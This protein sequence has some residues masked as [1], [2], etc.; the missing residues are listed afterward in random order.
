[1]ASPNI[2]GFNETQVSSFATSV[3]S[4]SATLSNPVVA[5]SLI[6]VSPVINSASGRMFNSGAVTDSQGNTYT[7]QAGIDETDAVGFWT[8]IAGSSGSLTVT[9]TGSASG[10]MSIFVAEHTVPGALTF[11]S[12]RAIQTT[13]LS[14][15]TAD[16]TFV[17]GTNGA[18]YYAVCAP[19]PTPAGSNPMGGAGIV[20]GDADWFTYDNGGNSG[21]GTIFCIAAL[22]ILDGTRHATFTMGARPGGTSTITL[23]FTMVCANSGT[24]P[25][26]DLCVN[27]ANIT[28]LPY[29]DTQDI[30]GATNSS[31]DPVNT[32]NFSAP[33]DHGIWY[34]WTAPSNMSVIADMFGS[35]QTSFVSGL[36]NRGL[37]Q[38]VVGVF[39]GACGGAW[40]QVAGKRRSNS[41]FDSPARVQFNAVSGTTY[42]FHIGGDTGG[43]GPA[44]AN[45][46]FNFRVTPS[47]PANDLCANATV[48]SSLP[49]SD[50]VDMVSATASVDDPVE[51]FFWGDV[52]DQT[53]FYKFTPAA[54]DTITIDLSA[55]DCD[56]IVAVYST[57]SCGSLDG[58]LNGDDRDDEEFT[59]FT[60]SVTAGTTYYIVLGFVDGPLAATTAAM[61]ITGTGVG[62][63]VPDPPTGVDVLLTTLGMH[64][65]VSWTAPAGG[66]TPDGYTIQ[67]CVGVGCTGFVT[68]GTTNGATSLTDGDM[69]VSTTYRYTVLATKTGVGASA[70]ANIATLVTPAFSGIRHQKKGTVGILADTS[71][72]GNHFPEPMIRVAGLD[73]WLDDVNVDFGSIPP[74]S[75]SPS[76][77]IEIAYPGATTVWPLSETAFFNI[78]STEPVFCLQAANSV[79]PTMKAIE[80]A[81]SCSSYDALTG[82][83]YAP[84]VARDGGFEFKVDGVTIFHV[85]NIPMP[86]DW[87][88]VNICGE[89]HLNGAYVKQIAEF[90]PEYQV[91]KPQYTTP[92]AIVCP[93]GPDV[94]YTDTFTDKTYTQVFTPGFWTDEHGIGPFAIGDRMVYG[95]IGNPFLV[96]LSHS[97]SPAVVPTRSVPPVPLSVAPSAATIPCAPVVQLQNGGRGKTGCNVGGFGWTPSFAGAPGAVPAHPDPI[98]GELLEG[99]MFDL[100][101]EV[102]VQQ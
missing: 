7:R 93:A 64:A 33:A 35:E 99:K 46:V 43:V 74:S 63:P 6:V 24:P 16:R 83:T 51:S 57:G 82:P 90:C 19:V 20:N 5:G 61:T 59:P 11:T 29:S 55:S 28:S 100:W 96:V 79:F 88:T 84:G 50:S 14:V 77:R 18:W 87:D 36:F 17:D 97:F 4:I 38:F 71:G 22:A 68:I 40:T 27:A 44:G 70:A 23:L 3:A 81:F 52:L 32:A 98:S 66:T 92:T 34:K 9:A 42:Y 54:D 47:A 25:V 85:I 65:T 58:E 95:V 101:V 39:T 26:N 12:D 75:P 21:T 89:G 8:A 60:I 86:T 69:L 73:V 13:G 45:A 30:A 56:I 78:A 67:R 2:N 102:D 80:L 1:M 48:I 49:Y 53:I 10:P 76:I 31:T 15:A 91:P 72:T 62:T 37:S 94:L 41:D